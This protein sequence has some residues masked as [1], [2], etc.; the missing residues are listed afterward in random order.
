MKKK[1]DALWF[2]AF[3]GPVLLVFSIVVLIPFFMG[4]YLSLFQWDGIPKNPKVYV[5]FQ[6]FIDVFQDGRFWGS[7]LLTLKYTLIAVVVINVLALLFALLLTTK[8]KANNLVRTMIFAP[9]MIG[10][11]I[12]GFAWK[13]IFNDVF[14]YI[15]KETGLDSIFFNWLINK[16]MALYAIVVVSTWSMAGYIMIIY[17]AGIQNISA[18]V[19]E[20]ASID[21]AGTFQVLRYITLPLLAPALTTTIFLTL[22]NS[23]K[24]YDVNLSLTNGGPGSATELLSMNIV[25]TIFTTSQYGYGQAKAIVFFVFVAAITLCQV[26]F[27]KKREANVQ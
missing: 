15:G 13:F 17:I 3:T 24:V 22:S 7:A 11:L 20:A 14:K 23:F 6:N 4:L 9:N 21:G 27:S 5:G 25:Q 12:L 10:G 19:M 1:S 26:Y 2:A 8:L 18:D 16:D